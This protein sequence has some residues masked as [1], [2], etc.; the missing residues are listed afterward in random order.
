M[1]K[2]SF[3]LSLFFFFFFACKNQSEEKKPEQNNIDS[4]VL[5]K[6][7]SE[8]EQGE[9]QKHLNEKAKE[10]EKE[11]LSKDAVVFYYNHNRN[12]IAKMEDGYFVKRVNGKVYNLVYFVDKNKKNFPLPIKGSRVVLSW[13]NGDTP[14]EIR[15]SA[16]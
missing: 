8:K 2:I 3:L 13:K 9:R 11:Y 7:N 14:F 10:K 4:L 5:Q 1:K 15:Y 6:I 16:W 12:E